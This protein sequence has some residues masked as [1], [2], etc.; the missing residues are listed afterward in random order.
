M[1]PAHSARSMTMASANNK[2]L[3][4]SGKSEGQ[5]VATV[6]IG[7]FLKALHADGW[8]E[9][10]RPQ[11]LIRKFLVDEGAVGKRQ[12]LTVRMR[13]TQA[14]DVRLAHQRLSAGIQI[15][16]CA[17]FLALRMM[18]SSVS[19]LMFSRLP[20]SAAQQPVQ[21]RLQA[22]VGSIRMAQ[23][24]LQPFSCLKRFCRAVPS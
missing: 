4:P 21:C 17:H 14:D 19:R 11:H 9:V 10:L 24:T 1:Q 20:Y 5:I 23:G 6:E 15:H 13:L 22:E 3:S 16:V 18:P 7:R 12:E 8:H 2:A